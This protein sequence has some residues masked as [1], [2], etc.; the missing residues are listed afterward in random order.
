MKPLTPEEQKLA[1]KMIAQ[2]IKEEIE[3][4]KQGKTRADLYKA[5]NESDAEGLDDLA[6]DTADELL[7]WCANKPYSRWILAA[8][9][10]I[11]GFVFWWLGDTFG[12]IS[13]IYNSQFIGQ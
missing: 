1:N 7:I 12:L 11:W 13:T 3:L 9:F 10:G 6:E 2:L 8:I 4:E 5:K